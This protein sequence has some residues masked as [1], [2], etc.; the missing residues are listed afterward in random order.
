MFML[1]LGFRGAFSGKEPT[2]QY[3]R[4]KRHG[5]DPSVGKIP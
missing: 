1:A 5:F 2:C 3:R 4:Y